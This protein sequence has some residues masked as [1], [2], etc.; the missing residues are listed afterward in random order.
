MWDTLGRDTGEALDLH[1][2]GLAEGKVGPHQPRPG[3]LQAELLDPPPLFLHEQTLP[4]L[5][6]RPS[7]I[8]LVP[9]PPLRPRLSSRPHG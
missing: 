1:D 2:D 7:R 9:R 5:L 3:T 6:L 8:I 4:V